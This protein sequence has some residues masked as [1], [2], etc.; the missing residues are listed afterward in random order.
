MT[1]FQLISF[2]YRKYIFTRG[3]LL[4]LLV[5]PVFGAF[6]AF[7][8]I[9][10]ERAAPVRAFA[11]I[12]ESGGTYTGVIDAALAREEAR[13]ALYVW[14]QY[15]TAAVP[16]GADGTSPLAAPFAPGDRTPARLNAFVAAGGIKAGTLA[17]APYL[18]ADAPAAPS[19]R[20]SFVRVP[21]PQAAATAA[22]SNAAL[23]ALR[24]YLSGDQTLPGND[25]ALFAVIVIPSDVA[26]G[27]TVQFWT[28]NLIDESLLISV[29][30]WITGDIRRAAFEAAGLDRDQL[31]EIERLSV[32]VA[33]FTLGDDGKDDGEAGA[34]DFVE[35]YLPLGLAYVLLLMITSVGSMLLTSTV[36]EKSNKIIEVLLSSVSATE[37]M[38]GKLV[39]LALVGITVP[40]IFLS[41]AAVALL[42]AGGGELNDA[43]RGV[44]FDSNLLPIF[45]AYF[46]VGYLLYASIYLAVGAMCSTI[47]DAQSFVMPLYLSMWVPFPFLQMIV[48]DPNGL[49][50]R[51]FTW[52]PIYTPFAVMMRISA[53][54]P[55]WEIIGASVLLLG[56]VIY[57][58][59][60][61]GRIYRNGVLSSGGAP[62]LK[63]VRE[64]AKH[65]A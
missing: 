25:R 5:I 47:Q 63:Q 41:S 45:F 19:V 48:Q 58:L 2:E 38:V 31:A 3:F 56:V 30:G 35:T 29:D 26:A 32:P 54:P 46:V 23:T 50:A 37:L 51:I 39:G 53:D 10:N 1:L 42:I 40:L 62:T 43:I 6:G 14:D 57:V 49:I 60:T 20:P 21:L 28:N 65:R 22:D 4:V 8:A 7:S 59:G 61:M 27:G 55:Q 9:I 13:E 36:E 17:A 12:D 52:I 11:V 33:R 15:V 24:P 18:A 44:L 16:V 34:V 64:L